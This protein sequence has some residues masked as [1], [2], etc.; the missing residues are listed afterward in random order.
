[1]CVLKS[2]RYK[3]TSKFK[4]CTISV[5]PTGVHAA[6]CA[7]FCARPALLKF[8]LWGTGYICML[9][10]LLDTRLQ[11]TQ[12][13]VIVT[14]PLCMGCSSDYDRFSSTSMQK[15]NKYA[16]CLFWWWYANSKFMNYLIEN[17]T[18]M[19]EFILIVNYENK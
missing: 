18:E 4:K 12:L 1:M 16:P 11:C 7:S 2:K 10:L 17:I 19:D 9:I 13:S 8:W 14:P 3:L 15:R 5:I 6:I